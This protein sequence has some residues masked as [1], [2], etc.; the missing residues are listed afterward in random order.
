MYIHMTFS[1]KIIPLHSTH[2]TELFKIFFSLLTLST[3]FSQKASGPGKYC[4]NIIFS[5]KIR[6]YQCNKII[7]LFAKSCET[8]FKSYGNSEYSTL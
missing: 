2:F 4:V 3:A 8:N 5:L 7:V 6:A 1:K